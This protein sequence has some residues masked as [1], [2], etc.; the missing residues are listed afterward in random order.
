MTVWTELTPEEKQAAVRHAVADDGL[1]YQQAANRL[2]TTRVAI[3]GVVERSLRKPNPIRSSGGQ[4]GGSKP[5]A[6]GGRRDAL[7]KKIKKARAKAKPRSPRLGSFLRLPS[8][9]SLPPVPARSDV[10]AALEGSAPVAIA[11]HTNGCRWPVGADLPFCYCNEP[12]TGDKVYC[13]AHAS[14]AYREPPPRKDKAPNQW[15]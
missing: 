2:G 9:E 13:A 4:K 3:A 8:E 14:I 1:T 7:T 10:W 12:V 5:G 6:A 11:E 15:R